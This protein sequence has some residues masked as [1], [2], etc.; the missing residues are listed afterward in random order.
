MP[1]TLRYSERMA[2]AHNPDDLPYPFQGYL[3]AKQAAYALGLSNDR[4]YRLLEQR[5][6]GGIRIANRW[7]L[8]PADLA[9]Y[10]ERRYGQVPALCS[11]A[12]HEPN[13]RL[14]EK[15]RRICEALQHGTSMT[16]ASRLLN[17]PRPSLYAQVQLVRK[18]LAR[19]RPE[20]AEPSSDAIPPGT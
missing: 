15:Q 1:D 13:I 14:T 12:L 19:I 3:T 9:A 2:T 8:Q 16:T 7:L 18:K 5:Q 20:F 6:L 4:V 17:L 10:R 11:M